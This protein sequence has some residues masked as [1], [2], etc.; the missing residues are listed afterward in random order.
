[1]DRQ[2]RNGS[3]TLTLTSYNNDE[4][5][6]RPCDFVVRFP[7]PIVLNGDWE[8]ALIDVS[9]PL[10]WLDSRSIAS[11]HMI[12]ARTAL[13]GD[14]TLLGDTLRAKQRSPPETGWVYEVDE[15]TVSGKPSIF[16]YHT[17]D[18]PE[19]V[20]ATAQELGNVL[21]A[22]ITRRLRDTYSILTPKLFD[23]VY[24]ENSKTGRYSIADESL[25]VFLILEHS[26]LADLL[27]LSYRKVLP[28]IVTGENPSDIFSFTVPD[29]TPPVCFLTGNRGTS[30]LREPVYMDAD[31]IDSIYVYC[32][33]VEPQLV[34]NAEA[35]L[36]N[37]APIKAAK[38]G[39]QV[40][41]FRS[42]TYLP[43]ATRNISSIRIALRSSRGRPIPFSST[44][45]SVVCVLHFQRCNPYI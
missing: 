18:L 20:Y 29:T 37:I 2:N 30:I 19:G 36:L 39:R 24:D 45:D 15:M 25:S 44:S 43:I 6:N 21:A 22:E 10:N 5:S 1:M 14:V 32:D 27:G 4:P 16:K 34:G 38:G 31:N 33:I 40:Y 41:T 42:P 8:V 13:E 9:F 12:S 35:P 3:F 23:Y 17:F 26:K 7:N 28:V 11:I